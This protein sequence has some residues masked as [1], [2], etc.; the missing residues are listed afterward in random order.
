MNNPGHKQKPSQEPD[1]PQWYI[2]AQRD[3]MRYGT[4][5]IALHDDKEPEHIPPE[6]YLEVA[7]T[8]KWAHEKITK[9]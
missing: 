1:A 7:E 2:D 8:L 4:G 3:A 5:F 6:K 9:G